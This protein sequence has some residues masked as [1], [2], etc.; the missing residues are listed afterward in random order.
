MNET[1]TQKLPDGP[2]IRREATF[3]R[4]GTMVA[5][6]LCLPGA[7]VQIPLDDYRANIEFILEQLLATKARVIWATCTPVHP[8]RP[9]SEEEWSWRNEELD[10]YNTAALEVMQRR[11]IPVNDLH[12]IVAADPDRLLSEDQLHLSETGIR[13]C[14]EAVVRA[15]RQHL[16]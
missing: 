10:Q 8:A 15:I 3:V 4:E 6:P 13:L 7:T 14:A 16:P 2:P 11:N 9:F 5:F 12:S 1:E